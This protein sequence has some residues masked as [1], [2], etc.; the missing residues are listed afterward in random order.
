ME[1]TQLEMFKLKKVIDAPVE[2]PAL[3][4]ID[5]ETTGVDNKLDHL[6]QVAVIITDRKFNVIKEYETPI[7]QDK[8]EMFNKSTPGVQK[9]HADTGLWDKLENGKTIEQVDTEVREMLEE[10][11]D[12][13]WNVKIWGNSVA[14]DNGFIQE[15]LPKSA[16]LLGHQVVDVSGILQFF[17]TIDNKVETNKLPTTHDALDD[18]RKT[19]DQARRAKSVVMNMNLPE[20]E[21]EYKF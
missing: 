11:W 4:F 8:E 16:E 21:K 14:F 6:L 2:K 19:I 15:N 9:M 13:K 7:Y 10:V 20:E 3:C 18:I 1:K 17:R 5:V 12:G